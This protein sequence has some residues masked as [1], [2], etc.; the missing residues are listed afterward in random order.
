MICG[1]DSI[2]EEIVSVFTNVMEEDYKDL[3]ITGFSKNVQVSDVVSEIGD[4]KIFLEVEVDETSYT[5]PAVDYYVE[6]INV[7][8]TSAPIN[9]VIISRKVGYPEPIPRVNAEAT[10]LEPCL[11]PKLLEYSGNP[12]EPVKFDRNQ[13]AWLCGFSYGWADAEMPSE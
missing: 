11:S 13:K 2:G 10:I 4:K 8:N 1:D 3:L 7:E 9:D 6:C 5:V 12:Y